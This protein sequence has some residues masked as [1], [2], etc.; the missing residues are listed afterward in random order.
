MA[1]LVLINFNHLH[2]SLSP[3]LIII[4]DYFR[5]GEAIN[6]IQLER[7]EQII[8]YLTEHGILSVNDAV[9]VFNASPATIRRDFNELAEQRIVTRVRGGIKMVKPVDNDMLPFALREVRHS[10]EKEALARHAVTLLNPGDA[11]IIDGGTTTFMLTACLPEI[12]L[13]IITNSLRLAAGLEERRMERA[14]LEVYISGGFLY[15][16]SGLL[17]G[18]SAQANLAQYHAHWAF[19]SVGG[20]NEGGIFNNNEWVV[21]TERVMLK[22]AGKIVVLADHSKIGKHAMCLVCDLERVDVL[23]TDYWPENEPLLS[24]FEEAGIDVVVVNVMPSP[25]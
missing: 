8:G 19:L 5:M 1:M 21:E 3:I 10:R 2:C 23:I 18:P 14:N 6:M 20:I 25:K 16:H 12:P 13:R 15:P 11:V 22:N 7:H 17:L 9:R 24:K 4:I